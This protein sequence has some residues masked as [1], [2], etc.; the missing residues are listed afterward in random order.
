M[1]VALLSDGV[2]T[3]SPHF[4]FLTLSLD[5][6]HLDTFSVIGYQLHSVDPVC[7][8]STLYLIQPFFHWSS[9]TSETLF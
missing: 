3:N 6:F 7:P 8:S 1:V 4:Q 2:T 9:S 5:S